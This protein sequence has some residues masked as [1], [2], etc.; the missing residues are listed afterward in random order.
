VHGDNHLPA[1]GVT[2]FLMTAF[3]AGKDK[4][5]SIQYADNILGIQSG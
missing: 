3:L 5:I 4:S 2:P 1:I